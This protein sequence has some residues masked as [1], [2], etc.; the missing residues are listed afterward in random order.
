MHVV[1]AQLEVR[2]ERCTEFITL[3]RQYARDCVRDQPGTLDF[4][5]IRDALLPGRFYAYEAFA[6]QAAYDAHVA[7]AHFRDA[8]RRFGPLLAEE[9]TLL[10]VGTSVT[11]RP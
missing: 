1:L 6:H 10:G 5:F 7:G 4:V 3:A 2:P 8:G 9:A 11:D